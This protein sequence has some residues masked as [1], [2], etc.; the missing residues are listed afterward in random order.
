[1]KIMAP[2]L[3]RWTETWTALGRGRLELAASAWVCAL[4][5]STHQ[6]KM[7]GLMKCYLNLATGKEG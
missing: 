1:M 5:I 2:R 4:E 7:P 6:S 3:W